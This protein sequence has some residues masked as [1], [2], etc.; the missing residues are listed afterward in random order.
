MCCTLVADVVYDSDI[1]V[2]VSGVEET[3]F[4]TDHKEDGNRGGKVCSY[5]T[6]S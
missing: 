1:I 3:V 4:H 5:R 2:V 6:C